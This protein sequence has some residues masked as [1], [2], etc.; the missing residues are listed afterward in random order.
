MTCDQFKF[1]IM[2][3]KSRRDEGKME[4]QHLINRFNCTELHDYRNDSEFTNFLLRQIISNFDF[5]FDVG[6]GVGAWD[7]IWFR[8]ELGYA[9]L[10]DRQTVSAAMDIH[11][12]NSYMVIKMTRVLYF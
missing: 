12:M 4:L 9:S 7:W 6:F 8:T 1:S 3:F 5:D 2:T 10:T 11:I